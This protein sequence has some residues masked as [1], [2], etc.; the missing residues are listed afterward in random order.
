MQRVALPDIRR[1]NVVVTCFG[2]RCINNREFR[3]SQ[4]TLISL[5]KMDLSPGWNSDLVCTGNWTNPCEGLTSTL[6][7]ACCTDLWRQ[8]LDTLGCHYH[9]QNTCNETNEDM[10]NPCHLEETSSSCGPSWPLTHG[11]YESNGTLAL[12]GLGLSNAWWLNRV[13]RGEGYNIAWE[14]KHD[15]ASEVN[16]I[17]SK[18]YLETKTSYMNC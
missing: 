8:I 1:L 7:P 3:Q 6:R 5:G 10:R 9:D 12:T 4:S 15:T 13:S 11:C 14:C 2:E 17:K 18:C 16:L